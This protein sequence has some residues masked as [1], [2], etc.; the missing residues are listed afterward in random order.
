MAIYTDEN[1]N[2]VK[3]KNYLDAAENLYG[4]GRS[5][6]D[7]S[8]T[9]YVNARRNAEGDG[10]ADVAVYQPGDKIGTFY[11]VQAATPKKHVLRRIK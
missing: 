1:G 9:T 3:A 11:G 8:Y 2:T 4:Q 6:Q 10:W 7:K 5:Y